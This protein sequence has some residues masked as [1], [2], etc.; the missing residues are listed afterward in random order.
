MKRK[1]LI[2]SELGGGGKG[3]EGGRMVE[4]GQV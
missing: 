4:K 2:E 3:G 1:S